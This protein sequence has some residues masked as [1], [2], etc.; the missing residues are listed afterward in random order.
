[1]VVGYSV[2]P[3]VDMAFVSRQELVIL[4]VRSGSRENLQRIV[5]LA[6]N[7]SIQLPNVQTWRLEHIN[8]ALSELR[9][10]SVAGK[11][12]VVP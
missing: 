5:N 3:D 4:G 9:A 8:D 6:A 11:A 12:V 2:V 7:G 1:M 10:G